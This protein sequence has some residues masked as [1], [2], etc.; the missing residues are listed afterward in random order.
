MQKTIL[1]EADSNVQD[2]LQKISNQQTFSNP[3]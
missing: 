1:N 2:I 3:L